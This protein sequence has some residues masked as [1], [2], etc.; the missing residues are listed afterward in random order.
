MRISDWSSDVCSS[1]LNLEAAIGDDLVGDI[2]TVDCAKLGSALND[3]NQAQAIAGD[4]GEAARNHRGF[5]EPGELVEQEQDRDID[6][7]LR[8]AAGVEIHELLK[9]QHVDR[10]DAVD[11]LSKEE[12]GWGEEK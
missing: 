11:M 7:A 5:A 4:V 9:E 1:D 6:R 10:R 2:G 12:R 8:K 3:R